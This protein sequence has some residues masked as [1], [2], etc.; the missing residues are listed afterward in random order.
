M[1][2]TISDLWIPDVWLATMR[3]KQATFPSLLNS[4]VVVD[5]PK[6]AELATGPGE[7]AVIPFF[8]DITDQDDEVQVE[9]QEPT[10]DNKITAGQMKA[11]ACNRV[12][13]NSATA[14]SAQLSGE[15][16]VGEMVAQMV[17]RKLK[18]RQKSLLAMLRG[19]FG[20]AG[21]SGVDA[22][23]KAVRMDAFDESGNDATVDQLMSIDLFIDSKGLM[24]E[25]ADDLSN[26]AL[27]LHPTILGALEKADETS[28]D[29]ASRGPW[30]I[31]TYR[32]IPIYVSESLVRA[33][34]TN[35]YVYDTYLLARG[36]VARGEKPQKTDVVDVAALQME[37]KFGLNNEIIYDRT[38]FV[39]HL[40]GMK[41][42]GTIEGESP[43]NAELGTIANW[44]LVLATA[45]RVGAVCIRTNG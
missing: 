26:G 29:K 34:T 44:N 42:V 45:N 37:R 16:P 12:T 27:W 36:I 20:S 25:L 19:A 1:P 4:G 15:D 40:N 23:L 30:T 41:W 14:F 39:M 2:T 13:K 11:V 28:F 7:V 32:G 18:Q 35:G 6:A 24:G 5:N 22:A 17:Q 38:R 21:A 3:E 43:E 8:R 31:R 9:N 10:V 33:G